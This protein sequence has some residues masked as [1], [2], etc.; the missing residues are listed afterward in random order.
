GYAL[1]IRGVARE[2]SHSTGARY[3]DP[4]LAVTVGEASGYPV[5]VDDDAPIRGRVGC[6]AFTA[7][8]VRGVDATRPTPSWMS[9]R[10]KLAGIR[11]ISLPVDI[12]NYVMLELGQPI[13]TYDL[14]RLTGGIVVR[15]AA[16]GETLTTL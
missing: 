7:R 11:S 3:R 16:V 13:H 2:Y 1:S 15:R 12:S 5:R 6:D 14:G 10:L 9:S 8:V 4:A